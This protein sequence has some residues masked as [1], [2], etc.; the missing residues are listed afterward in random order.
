MSDDLS[1]NNCAAKRAYDSRAAARAEA[2]RIRARCKRIR[3]LKP[4]RCRHCPFWHLTKQ[5]VTA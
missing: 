1:R 2:K 4:Y 5:G 3:P